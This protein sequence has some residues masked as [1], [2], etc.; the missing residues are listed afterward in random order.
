MGNYTLRKYDSIKLNGVKRHGEGLRI[1]CLQELTKTNTPEWEQAVYRF[2]I[3]WLSF[4]DFV[5]AHTSGSTGK[6]KEIRLQKKYMI[7]SALK[8]IDFFNLSEGKTVLLCLSANYIAGKMMLIRAMVGGFNL[9]LAE[10]TGAPLKQ[11][12]EPIDFTAMVP[13]Q[14]FN[15][16]PDFGHKVKNVIIGGGVLSSELLKKM[17][18]L[19]TRF[20][21]T[22]GMTETV[23]HVAV[24]LIGEES[25]PFKAMPNV[26]FAIDNRGCLIITAPDITDHPIVTNDIVELRDDCEFF[27]LGRYDNVINSGGVKIIPEEVERKLSDVLKV[28]FLISAVP[29]E[30]LGEKVVVVLQEYSQGNLSLS[31]LSACLSPYEIPKAI[32]RIAQFPLTDSGKVKRYEVR[33][34]IAEEYH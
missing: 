11:I 31:D 4:E 26:T 33:K 25:T 9:L 12:N 10:P 21:E 1:F 20:F 22:Y 6:P 29:D 28:P 7:A 14:V 13:L 18:G 15:S 27:F 5:T 2:I 34:M 3:E 17:H 30:K 32:L 19:P 8:T 23:S 24:K 16:L